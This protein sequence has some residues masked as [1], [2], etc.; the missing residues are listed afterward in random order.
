MTTK[1]TAPS[2]AAA[3]AKTAVKTPVKRV[4]KKVA[5]PVATTPVATTPV[6]EA[7]PAP[8]VAPVPAVARGEFETVVRAEAH[9]LAVARGYRDGSPFSDWVRA[10]AAVLA[11]FA[12]EGRAVAP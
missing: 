4:A 6:A 11:R 10:E 7:A 1:K 9:A 8:P 2:K 3:S 12:A 5:A